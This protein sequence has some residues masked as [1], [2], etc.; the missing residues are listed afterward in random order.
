L[1]KRSLCGLCSDDAEDI[2]ELTVHPIRPI[3]GGDMQSVHMCCRGDHILAGLAKV[4]CGAP[5]WLMVVATTLAR[6]C[7]L[8]RSILVVCSILSADLRWCNSIN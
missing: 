5:S 1:L 7:A 4:G 8:V 2:L 6:A 3:G